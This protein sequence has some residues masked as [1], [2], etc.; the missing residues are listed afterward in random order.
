M[1]YKGIIIT[2]TIIFAIIQILLAIGYI[3]KKK[4]KSIIEITAMSI[5]YVF[6]L[7]VQY[8]FDFQIKYY[9]IILVILSY[10]GSVFVGEY[11]NIYNTSK[12]YDWFLHCFGSFSVSLFSYALIEKLIVQI[13]YP[14]ILRTI[15]IASLGIALGVL[16]EILE[17]LLDVIF[18]TYHQKGLVDTNMDLIWNIGGSIIAAFSSI[19][20]F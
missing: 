20:V 9:L 8:R 17:F 18:R 19:Y 12:H 5:L 15:L 3:S 2:I 6:F 16:F 11:L 7:Y 14:I 4:Y 13:N 10:I 1:T